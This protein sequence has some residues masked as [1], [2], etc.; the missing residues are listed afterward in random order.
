MALLRTNNGGQTATVNPGG[1]DKALPV[2]SGGGAGG[3]VMSCGS[4]TPGAVASGS[5]YTFFIYCSIC[6]E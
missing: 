5:G 6:P 2:N 3:G 4:Y 1:D